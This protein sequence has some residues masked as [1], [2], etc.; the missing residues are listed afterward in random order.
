LK[1]Y[2]AFNPNN[3][4]IPVNAGRVQN[5]DLHNSIVTDYLI[6]TNP[7][8]L[9][10]VERLA[11]FHRQ[12]NNLKV[13]VVTV[14]KIF[15]EFSSGSQDPVAIRDFAKMYFD[16]AASNPNNRPKY[17]LFF[18]DASF[19]YKNRIVN[20]TNLVPSYQS[21]IFLDPLSTY[22]SDDFF[23]FLDDNEDIN[24]GLV[25][26]LLDIGIGR[27]PAKNLDEAKNYVDKVF[28]YYAKESFG[29]WRNNIS[30]IADDE[31]N[32]RKFIS[33]LFNRRVGQP[34]AGTRQ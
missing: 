9:S 18:G 27:I 12:K 19:D 14:D 1:E 4:L 3:A 7:L 8:L 2:I 24:S 15:N 28:A 5:Q 23:G 17:L 26:N 30:F 10:Q 11:E 21:K 20:N 22:T 6:V 16:K 34:E 29:A 25:T 32:N 13:T 33:M 31:D